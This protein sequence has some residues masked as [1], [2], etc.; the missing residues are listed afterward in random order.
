MKPNKKPHFW[1][2]VGTCLTYCKEVSEWRFY[3][4]YNKGDIIT[5]KQK[6]Y[7]YKAVR[8]VKGKSK[9]PGKV[10]NDGKVFWQ[11]IGMC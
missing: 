4:W 11:Q 10:N 9:K 8:K 2:F 3:K 7:M 5:D 1:N 6:V